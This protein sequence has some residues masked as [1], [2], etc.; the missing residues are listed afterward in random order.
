MG[1]TTPPAT[2]ALRDRSGDD[3]PGLVPAYAVLVS[4]FCRV[5]DQPCAWRECQS[6]VSAIWNS[7]QRHGSKH[8]TGS[9]LPGALIAQSRSYL[10]CIVWAPKLVLL[11]YILR[12]VGPKLDPPNIVWAPKLVLLT[13]LEGLEVQVYELLVTS[14]CLQHFNS[15]LIRLGMQ[16]FD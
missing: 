5:G 10:Y 14:R 16:G 12:A 6:A 11:N 15:Q 2:A 3:V 13:C 9:Y 7:T 8:T 4:V 1:P